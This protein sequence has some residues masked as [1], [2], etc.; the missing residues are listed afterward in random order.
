LVKSALLLQTIEQSLDSMNKAEFKIA[1]VVLRAPED[2]TRSTIAMLANEA[3]VSEPSVNRFCKK[4]GATGFPDFKLRLTKC[5]ATGVRYVSCNVDVDDDVQAYTPKVF[6]STINTLAE[7]RDSISTAQVQAVVE[8]LIN[9]KRIYFYGL[10]ASSAVAKDAEHKFFRFKLPVSCH[11]DVLMQR[12]LA[13]AASEGDVFL[14]ISHTGRT[15]DLVDTA[16]VIKESGAKLIALTAND[17][18][19]G[20]LAD[21]LIG[22]DVKE[23]TYEYMPMMSRLVHLVILD[24]LATGITLYRGEEYQPHLKKIKESLRTTRYSNEDG[25]PNP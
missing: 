25:T 13:A 22:I 16:H 19:L 3:G 10:G 11:D 8:A 4:F 12:M 9:A 14:L 2:A 21:L 20:D 5:L 6:D 7:V 23:N 17:T 15:R 24:V 1:E 18:P